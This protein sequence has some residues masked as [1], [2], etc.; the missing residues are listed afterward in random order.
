MGDLHP[1]QVI[2]TARLL[3]LFELAC[4]VG[5]GHHD[6]GDA[7]RT[8]RSPDRP[9]HHLLLVV[10]RIGEAYVMS[11][12]GGEY[13]ASPAAVEHRSRPVSLIEI[14]LIFGEIRFAACPEDEQR[15]LEWVHPCILIVKDRFPYGGTLDPDLGRE[16][17]V[18]LFAT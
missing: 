14:L 9:T 15:C 4:G 1:D 10:P 3:V 11:P 12:V 17:V 16:T 7:L 8:V 2:P 13:H 5:E 18:L 6:P